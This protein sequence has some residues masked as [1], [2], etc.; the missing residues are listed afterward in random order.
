MTADLKKQM[1]KAL[2]EVVENIWDAAQKDCEAHALERLVALLQTA[3]GVKA[4]KAK[5]RRKVNMRC[6][7]VDCGKRSMGPRYHYLCADHLKGPLGQ[8]LGRKAKKK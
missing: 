3:P 8:T 4:K 7:A 1:A 5:P 6:R 2:G